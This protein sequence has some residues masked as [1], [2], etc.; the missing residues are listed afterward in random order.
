MNHRIVRQMQKALSLWFLMAWTYTTL[1]NISRMSSSSADY[2]FKQ[3]TSL[4][5]LMETKNQSHWNE[6]KIGGFFRTGERM[7]KSQF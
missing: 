3:Q 6:V 4:D 1:E 2:D 7:A 5:Q